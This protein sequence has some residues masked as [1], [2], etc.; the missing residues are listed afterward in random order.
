MNRYSL[1]MICIVTALLVNS[2]EEL[3]SSDAKLRIT[4]SKL[5]QVSSEL[6]SSRN[7]DKAARELLSIIFQR[8]MT[9]YTMASTHVTVTAYSATQNETDNSPELTANMTP[10]RIGL[11]AVSRDLLLSLSYGQI[12]ILD[13][14]GVFKVSDT[15]NSRF[16]SRVDILHSSAKSARL[17]GK[18]SS[19]LRWVF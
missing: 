19:T 14:Y 15:M 7:S 16:T 8:D 3:N 13:G 12:V 2:T 1:G 9:D 6:T 17:F 10:S 4:E 5:N 18:K 11:L